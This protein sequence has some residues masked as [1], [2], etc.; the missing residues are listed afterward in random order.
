MPSYMCYLNKKKTESANRSVYLPCAYIER[1]EKIASA[2]NVS[3]SQILVSM[4]AAC[5][6]EED[7]AAAK[8]EP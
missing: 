1:I 3:F 4:I 2:N 6:A 8:N 7:A 5:F